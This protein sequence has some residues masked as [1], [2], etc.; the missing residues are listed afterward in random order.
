VVLLAMQVHRRYYP[1]PFLPSSREY[2]AVGLEE[3]GL[4]GVP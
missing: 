2:D 4:D 3:A 1:L